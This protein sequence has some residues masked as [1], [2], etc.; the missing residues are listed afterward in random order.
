[1]ARNR[2]RVLFLRAES[3][4]NWWARENEFNVSKVF[5]RTERVYIIKWTCVMYTKQH[6]LLLFS[7]RQTLSGKALSRQIVYLSTR[8]RELCCETR[9]K[10]VSRVGHNRFSVYTNI[11]IDIAML[12]GEESFSYTILNDFVRNF[13]ESRVLNFESLFFRRSIRL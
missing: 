4:Q 2:I 1:M 13:R 6:F 10:A 12:N 5:F 9:L 7:R 3:I 11:H 8:A